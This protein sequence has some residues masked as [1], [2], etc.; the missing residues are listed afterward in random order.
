MLHILLIFYVILHMVALPDSLTY[1]AKWR[2]LFHALARLGV[3]SQGATPPGSTTSNELQEVAQLCT[4]LVQACGTR[5]SGEDLSSN[6]RN[7]GIS[8]HKE[9]E[10]MLEDMRIPFVSELVRMLQKILDRAQ[11]FG[12][13]AGHDEV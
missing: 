5:L 4:Q 10:N 6:K 11:W 2:D 9:Q 12:Q 3:Q 13:M 8:V 7:D 1:A